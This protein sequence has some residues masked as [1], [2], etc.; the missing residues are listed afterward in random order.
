MELDLLMYILLIIF[1]LIFFSFLFVEKME[2][3]MFIIIFILS[4]FSGYK[5]LYDMKTS[6]ILNIDMNSVQNTF[7][8]AFD[9]LRKFGSI[10]V[11]MT[12]LVLF[13]ITFTLFYMNYIPRVGFSITTILLSI[14]ILFS[15]IS[16]KL[17]D[18]KQISY[19]LLY[20]GPMVLIMTSLIMMMDSIAKIDNSPINRMKMSR[21]NREN[22]L[23]Y[24]IL[25]FIS[26]FIIIGSLVYSSA[27]KDLSKPNPNV[28]AIVF[29][30]IIILYITSSYTMYYSNEI[31]LVHRNNN[32]LE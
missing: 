3:I 14:S 10:G 22:L 32:K 23:A 6:E 1:Y 18:I 2:G 15:I 29:T 9:I 4:T 30:C 28:D 17:D 27:S 16:Q 20:I 24:K 19:F 12:L 21:K 11:M 5:L 26:T 25:L 13:A 7:S 8:F 31:S